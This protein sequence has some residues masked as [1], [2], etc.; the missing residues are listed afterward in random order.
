MKKSICIIC[1]FALLISFCACAK[2]PA[3]FPTPE[4]VTVDALR[5][6][7][8]PRGMLM[9][10]GGFEIQWRNEDEANGGE[11]AST[12]IMRYLSGNEYTE[13]NQI[14]DYDSGD[15]TLLYF[16][17][18]LKD[19]TLFIE[20]AEGCSTAVLSD[21]EIQNSL[22][23]TLFGLEV[24]DCEITS[25]KKTADGYQIEYDASLNGELVQQVTMDLDP[26]SGAVKGAVISFIENGAPV[27]ETKVTVTYGKDV[28]ID[29]SP[30]DKAIEMGIYD[31]EQAK[32]QA[33]AAM[34]GS[35]SKFSFAARDM[36]GNLVSR[37]DLGDAKLVM[38]NYWEPW[39]QPCVGEMEDLENLYE[40]YKD[41]GFVILGVL[42]SFDY[43]EE[44]REVI[45]KLGI[46][47]P[48][49]HADNHL[50]LYQTDSVPTTI[51][52]DGE[53]NVLTEEPYIGARDYNDWL[54]II[55]QYMSQVDSTAT[56]EV[57]E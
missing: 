26:D 43:D 56:A 46:T 39:C 49:V 55:T 1:I 25:A 47:Y 8:T 15:H 22:D 23:D 36:D 31:P 14:A 11:Y 37:H 42:S 50:S 54:T 19:P 18:D 24:Y 2:K 53:G 10:E 16:T 33:E 12:T 51:F 20:N 4:D 57:G 32:A 44:A 41:S 3:T 52:I 21:R 48:I 28:K 17:S 45:S 29:T 35:A 40:D 38:V 30:R 27:G 6:L 7:T 9:H 34:D 13:I 5:T